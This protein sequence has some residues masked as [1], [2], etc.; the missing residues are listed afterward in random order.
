LKL[1]E[2]PVVVKQ[3]AEAQEEPDSDLGGDDDESELFANILG[4]NETSTGNH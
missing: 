3:L 2:L 4:D 1:K